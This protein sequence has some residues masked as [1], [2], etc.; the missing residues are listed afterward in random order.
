MS[1][2]ASLGLALFSAC[3]ISWQI[4]GF[5]SISVLGFPLFPTS[6]SQVHSVP[7]ESFLQALP[8]LAQMCTVFAGL[9]LKPGSEASNIS[10]SLTWCMQVPRVWCQG[11]PSAEVVVRSSYSAA[12]LPPNLQCQATEQDEKNLVE[13]TS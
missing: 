4:R 3:S 6:P 9:H 12:E 5:P 8:T 1:C 2:I 13:I 11:L 10:Q 7:S